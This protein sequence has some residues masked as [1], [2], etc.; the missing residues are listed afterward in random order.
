MA[1]SI[2]LKSLFGAVT[3]ALDENKAELNQ[4]GEKHGDEMVDIFNTITKAVGSKQD[5]AP[6]TQ[7][8]N[9]AKQVSKLGGD[10]A[11][12][13]SAG[14]AAAA[15]AFQGQSEVN[16]DNVGNLLG[17]LM[18]GGQTS[19][20]GSGDMMGMLGSLMGGGQSDAGDMAGMLGGLMGGGQSSSGGAGG[21]LGSLLGGGSGGGLLGSLMGGSQ[22]SPVDGL[23]DMAI[24]SGMI[25]VKPEQAASLK[26]IARTVLTFIQ[27]MK[28]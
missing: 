13:Y 3:S 6:T 4:A 27:N 21:L 2:D 26:V 10:N 25:N 5:A 28:K 18:G 1:D 22:T 8:E 17:S 7:F 19:A 12:L 20:D 11:G 16:T 9:A 24:S 23:I 15:Q 14:L